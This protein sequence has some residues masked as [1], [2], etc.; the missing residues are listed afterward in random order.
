[1]ASRIRGVRGL[2]KKLARMPEAIKEEMRKAM[3]QGAD[4]V[5]A[6][7]KSLVPVD[8]GDLRDSIGWT[9]G[10]PPKGSIILGNIKR[11]AK[12]QARKDAGLLITI[13]AGN[14]QAYYAR[15][16]EFGTVHM[17]ARPYFYPSYRAVRKRVKS[18]VTRATNKAIK[19]VAAGRK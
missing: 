9:W 6:L 16:V 5:V 15:W 14:D 1:M 17:T 19:Q 10:D 7:A 11:S 4:E 2:Q 13:Y 18:R 12:A 3:A 8:Q